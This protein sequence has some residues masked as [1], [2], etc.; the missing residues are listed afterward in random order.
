MVAPLF[1]LAPPRSFT[2]VTCAMLGQHPQM[3]GLPEM[4]LF[5]TEGM[6][7]WWV[8]F[9]RARSWPAHGVLRAV[10]QLYFDE[11]TERTIELARWWLWRRL[12]HS[13]GTVFREL[14]GKV[15]PLILV[16]KSPG[17]SFRFERL[18]RLHRAF[19][20]AKF[21]HLVRH[22]RAHGESTITIITE[23]GYAAGI[24]PVLVE[25]WLS[26][27]GDPQHTW[28]SNN[29]RISKFL[30]PLPEEQKLRLRGEDLLADPDRHLKEIA[31]WLGL[32][33][34]DEAIEQMKHPERS[35]FACFG[36]PNASLGGNRHFLEQPALRRV[37]ARPEGLDG[38]LPWRS[39][40]AE[41]SPR[42]KQLAREFGYH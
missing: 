33:T 2:S 29:T 11:Q 27:G 7:E 20:E 16:H 15:H 37:Q 25:S 41:F 17:T 30:K 39:D 10:A 23:R 26:A 38:P 31:D 1:I 5:T 13:T 14:A 22:P 40:G 3:Y 24:D 32:R 42:V 8:N 12:G 35:P 9:H 18:R 6:Q 36:P 19:P 28:Y 21:L 4:S 34:D